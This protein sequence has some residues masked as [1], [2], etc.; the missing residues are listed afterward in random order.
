LLVIAHPLFG[1][2]AL[3]IALEDKD[4]GMGTWPVSLRGAV[5]SSLFM[6]VPILALAQN[7]IVL[8][9]Q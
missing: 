1:F 5:L 3:Q 9:D 6:M 2:K 4:A 8:E 7:A